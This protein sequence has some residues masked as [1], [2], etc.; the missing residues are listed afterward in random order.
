MQAIVSETAPVVWATII[1]ASA[2]LFTIFWSLDAVT[3]K[4]LAQIDISDNE[5]QTHRTILIA[6]LFMEGSLVLMFWFQEIML[7]F[8][9]AFFITRLVH[10]FIDELKYHADRC[11]PYESNLHLGMWMSVLIK[12]ATMFMWGYFTAFDG[13]LDLPI[14]FILWAGLILLVMSYVS[15]VEWKR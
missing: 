13:V 2:T 1:L 4:K 8:F 6:S 10:E 11:T 14:G 12:T 9:I 5:F 3:H 15:W 7:P